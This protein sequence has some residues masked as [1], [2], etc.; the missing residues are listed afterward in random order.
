VRKPEERFESRLLPLSAR[1][2]REVSELIPQLYLHGLAEGTE[3]VWFYD[4]EADGWSLDDKRTPL[5]SEDKV[6]PVPS[7]FRHSRRKRESSLSIRG[8]AREEQPARR[9]GALGSAQRQRARTPAHRSEFLRAMADIARTFVGHGSRAR[10]EDGASL[11]LESG[12]SLVV[13]P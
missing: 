4:V 7:F 12:S 6:G 1:R 3:F 5:L 11:R 8:R 2:T 13:S 10:I 9:A